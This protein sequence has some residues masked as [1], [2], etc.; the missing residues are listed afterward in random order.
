MMVFSRTRSSFISAKC[1]NHTGSWWAS[2][3]V[4]WITRLSASSC[5]MARANDSF[6]RSRASS[7]GTESHGGSGVALVHLEPRGRGVPH[8]PPGPQGNQSHSVTVRT[9]S[10]D[11][12][13]RTPPGSH[14]SKPHGGSSRTPRAGAMCR[15]L[16]PGRKAAS[17]TAVLF[18][19]RTAVAFVNL[20][21]Y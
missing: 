9:P 18:I 5:A 19:S 3:Q 7:Q 14:G 2:S 17:R 8:T 20:L 4:A 13:C 21:I 6:C 1:P 10:T 12:V 15:T 16:K 11:A